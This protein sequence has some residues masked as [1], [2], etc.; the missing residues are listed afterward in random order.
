MINMSV[1]TAKFAYAHNYNK[2]QFSDQGK[3]VL[4]ILC[5]PHILICFWTISLL[6]AENHTGSQI[7]LDRTMNSNMSSPHIKL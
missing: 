3:S 1:S 2:Y 6:T 5:F 7:I 4:I